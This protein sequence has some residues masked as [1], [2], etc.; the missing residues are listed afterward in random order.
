[1]MAW[2]WVLAIIVGFFAVAG[3]LVW[4]GLKGKLGVSGMNLITKI[5]N[6]LT[7][8]SAAVSAAT[9]NST[10]DVI[11]LVMQLVEKAVH[12]AENAYYNNLITADERYA[13]C[14]QYF[15]EMLVA[16]GITLDEAQRNIVDALI[17]AACEELGHNTVITE[18]IAA[19]AKTML[20]SDSSGVDTIL[21]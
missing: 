12:A 7:D 15:D 16:A 13:L 20:L 18:P 3:F 17:K 4:L 10:I 19:S 9:E 6:A 8:I 5:M 11:A 1:M 21:D 2:Y 14:M